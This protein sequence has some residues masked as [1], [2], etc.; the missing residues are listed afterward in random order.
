MRSILIA[1]AL[2]LAT[3]ACVPTPSA[4]VSTQSTVLDEKALYAAEAAYNSASFTY[5]TLVDGGQLDGTKK[6]MVKD[7][8]ILAYAALK[9]LRTAYAVGDSTTLNQQLVAFNALV[10]DVKGLMQ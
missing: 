7:K 1:F 8:L 3:T 6:T 5:L 10:T 4:P 9:A 2:A